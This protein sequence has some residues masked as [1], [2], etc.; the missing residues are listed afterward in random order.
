MHEASL[1]SSHDLIAEDEGLVVAA[2][3]SKNKKHQT[4]QEEPSEEEI[5]ASLSRK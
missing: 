4:N 5:V 2:R 3:P 1:D